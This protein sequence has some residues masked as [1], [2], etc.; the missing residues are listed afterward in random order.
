M[1]FTIKVRGAGGLILTH[2]ECPEHGLFEATVQR[3]ESGDPPAEV[4]CP[5]EERDQ[6]PDCRGERRVNVCGLTAEW[7]PT[8]PAI[9]PCY[10]YAAV[11]GKDED[12]P[13]GMLDTRMLGEGASYKEWRAVQD[14]A[15]QE[16][17][18]KKLIEKGLKTR[19]VQV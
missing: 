4:P 16:R 15:R 7:R 17:R 5:E 9:K 12:R 13:P 19:R 6:W 18:H 2:Y 3:D 14:K 1:S 11:R 8:A 10:G